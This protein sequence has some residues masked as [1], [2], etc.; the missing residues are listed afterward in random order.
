MD[1]VVDLSY[2]AGWFQP[3]QKHPE[4]VRLFKLHLS[5][6]VRLICPSLWFYEVLNLLATGV[7]RG[8]LSEEQAD[9]GLDLLNALEIQAAELS[10]DAQR[11]RVHRFARQFKLSAYDAAYL[12]LADR[13][14]TPLL[15]RDDE[16]IAAA[17]Q[18]NLSVTLQK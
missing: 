15:T 9:A 1:C 5:G 16:L 7:R 6:E 12:E 13:L 8:T 17:R 11:K 2:A 10:S 14:Q 18:R 4:G 3:S